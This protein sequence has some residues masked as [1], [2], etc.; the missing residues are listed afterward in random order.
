M[1]L[2]GGLALFLYGLDRLVAA[3][4]AVAGK[5]LRNILAGLTGN[6]Y[7][8]AL[9][10]ALVTAVIQ[11]SSVTTVLVVG[12]VSTQLMSLTQAI[13]VIIGANVG[14]TITAQIV[15]FKVTQYALLMIAIGFAIEFLTK[16][17][18]L[19]HYGQILMSLGLVFFGMSLMGDAMRPLQSYQPFLGLMAE[20]ANPLTGIAV[21]ALFTALIQS[22]SA[23]TAIIIVMAGQG[24]ITLPAGIALVFGA[25]IGTCVTAMLAAIGKPRDAVRAALAHVLFNVIGVLLW[26]GFIEQMAQWIIWLSPV[27]EDL[28]GTAKLAAEAP[29]Q[30]A[31]ANTLFNLLNCLLFLPFTKQLAWLVRQFVPDKP[32]PVPSETRPQYLDSL[33]LGTPDLAFNAVHQELKHLGEKVQNMLAAGMPAVL[34]GDREALRRAK[35]MDEAIDA[36]HGHIVHYLGEISK[37]NLSREETGELLH[38]LETANS[39]ENIGDLIETDLINLGKQRLKQEV[40]ISPHTRQMLERIQRE[41]TQLLVMA[42]EAVTEN[43]AEKALQVIGMKGAVNR[44]LTEASVH[45]AQRLIADAPDRV[46]TYGLEIDI[47]EKLRRIYYFTKRIAKAV[48]VDDRG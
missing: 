13:G 21:A 42:V 27:A 43:D 10:G 18:T 34:H 17:E 20:M 19:R 40:H 36:L 12:F 39:L 3:L 30:I 45:E 15:A 31:N 35:K 48:L 25:S 26:L 2:F 6:R 38:L 9:T 37:Q 22:S 7:L 32:S 46:R 44:L 8:G 23:T 24:F 1:G 41:V 28:S 33:L 47:L 14:T 5:G 29:R 11:S 16:R 4:K